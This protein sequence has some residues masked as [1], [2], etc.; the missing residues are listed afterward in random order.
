MPET[1]AF[2][3]GSGMYA[4]N[5]RCCEANLMQQGWFVPHEFDSFIKMAGGTEPLIEKL[6][7]L[8]ENTP[9][10]L[11]WTEY[12]HHGNEPQHWVPFLYN[13]LGQPWKS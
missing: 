9:F 13:K 10:K 2:G 8:F 1:G 5:Y 11:G 6:D 12:Y 4:L 7:E 3:S